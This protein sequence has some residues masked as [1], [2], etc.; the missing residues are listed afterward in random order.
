MYLQ[1]YQPLVSYGMEI[2]C[3][4]ASSTRMRIWQTQS[5]PHFKTSTANQFPK[6]H[7]SVQ[8]K[9]KKKEKEKDHGSDLS[10]RRCVRRK[11]IFH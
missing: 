8:T 9:K 4:V 10:S 6:D 5:G 11:V 1:S 2:K 3:D 7:G